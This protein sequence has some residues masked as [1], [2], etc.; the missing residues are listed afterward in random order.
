MAQ[1]KNINVEKRVSSKDTVFNI[2][3]DYQG[4]KYTVEDSQRVLLNIPDNYNA[5]KKYA[6]DTQRALLNILDDY[7]AEKINMENTQRAVLNILEDYADEKKKVEIANNDLASANKELEQ[8]AYVA[9]HDL[10]EPLR[11]IS[12]FA[13]LLEEKYLGK[14]DEE[15]EQYL[16]FIVG[17]A[18]K[19]QNLIKGLLD[20]SRIGRNISFATI[21]CNHLLKEVIENLGA[22]I[23]ESNANITT[24]V[25]PV[26]MGN[27]IELK[28]LFQNLLSNSIKFRKKNTAP[29]ISIAVEEKNMNYIF[30]I[31]DNGI[32]IEKKY[33]EK[34]FIIF[35]RLHNASEYSGTGIGLA[36]CKKIVALHN[37]KIWVES[38]LGE[39]S[40]FH[41]TI[42]K[43]NF[44]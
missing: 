36:T 40:T 26:V 7:A 2:S 21:D 27:E 25:L 23:E 12:N 18:S 4:E 37:G 44:K 11:T 35:Q 30:S 34:I 9:S 3:D 42:P 14:A 15:M 16:K 13:L 1:N 32:G 17:A 38:K 10:Q 43:E 28:Q 22:S 6:D 19:M 29:E 33:R 41:F 8:F 31:Q 5:E 39:G 20:F 24:S